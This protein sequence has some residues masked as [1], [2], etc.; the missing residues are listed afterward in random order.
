M[1]PASTK[2]QRSTTLWDFLTFERMMT[3]PVIHLIYW[4]A[5]GMIAI[6]GFG[7]VGAG[8]G[9]GMRDEGVA[10][11]LLAVGV[12]VAGLLMVGAFALIWR[13]TCEFFVAI[14]R[15]SDDLRALRRSDEA[16][17]IEAAK[18]SKD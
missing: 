2:R 7:V 15:I 13:G 10:G 8:V 18:A 17:V 3:G 1:R 12:L 16:K 6:V 4:A 5:L 11:W 14:F 9:L